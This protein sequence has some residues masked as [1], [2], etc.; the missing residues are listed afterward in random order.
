MRKKVQMETFIAIYLK[1]NKSDT[2][3]TLFI[4]LKKSDDKNRM[5]YNRYM[6]P[7]EFLD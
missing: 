1:H 7:L 4:V 5:E 3:I 6:P 2:S